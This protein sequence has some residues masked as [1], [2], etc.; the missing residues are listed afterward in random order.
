MPGTRAA[1]PLRLRAR[2]VDVAVRQQVVDL[3]PTYPTV[4]P[5]S[6]EFMF[7]NEVPGLGISAVQNA[8]PGAAVR[9]VQ[10]QRQLPLERSGPTTGGMPSSIGWKAVN[11]VSPVKKPLI[12]DGYGPSAAAKTEG[13]VG[14]AISAADY[15]VVL[16]PIGKADARGEQ[17]AAY[18]DTHV[19]W[20]VAAAPDEHHVCG[21]VVRSIPREARLMS[22]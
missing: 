1:S 6:G 15:R 10:R 16:E 11:E 7:H 17:T 19:V 18:L 2:R 3:V 9:D 8:A 14:D 5:I 4:P 12:V 13:V 21:W 22:G 20:R